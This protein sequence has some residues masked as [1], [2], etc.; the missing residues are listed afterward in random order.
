VEEN[1][2][3][4]MVSVETTV[5]NI[6]NEEDFLLN[7]VTFLDTSTAATPL[8][9][10]TN[11]THEKALPDNYCPS[12]S[13]LP[14]APIVS[15]PSTNSVDFEEIPNPS[16]EIEK[17]TVQDANLNLQRFPSNS[18]SKTNK[19]NSETDE[20]FERAQMTLSN[21]PKELNNIIRDAISQKISQPLLFVP[22]DSS[23][24]EVFLLVPE[25]DSIKILCAPKQVI[26]ASKE[27]AG[28]WA[29]SDEQPA[30]KRSKIYSLAEI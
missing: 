10:L 17:Q 21:L 3:T 28:K 13:K 12:Q 1:T 22:K 27:K 19:L 5:S 20:N 29:K 16:S 4:P 2:E 6:E 9:D 11:S 30:A 8:V 14:S 15:S 24:N 25:D 23:S 7:G 26:T 18:S